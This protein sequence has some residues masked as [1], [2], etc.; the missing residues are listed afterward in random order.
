M[1]EIRLIS[2]GLIGHVSDIKLIRTDTTLDLSQ[3]AE[4]G[5][6]CFLLLLSLLQAGRDQASVCGISLSLSLSILVLEDD[7][8]SFFLSLATHK[9]YNTLCPMTCVNV[10]THTYIYIYIY[11]H[12][13]LM[14]CQCINTSSIEER[15]H[16]KEVLEGSPNELPKQL[17][18]VVVRRIFHTHCGDNGIKGDA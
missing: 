8:I 10:A 5:M 14:S 18:K 11:L 1:K 12:W 3:K 9:L 2:C 7:N 13:D 16:S 6:N 15:Q 17:P 4:K